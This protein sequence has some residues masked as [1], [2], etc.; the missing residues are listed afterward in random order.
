MVWPAVLS[1][2]VVV[3]FFGTL[4]AYLTV[5]LR[6]LD[7]I[8]GRPTSYLAKI[9]LGVRAIESETGMLGPQVSR[10]ND[11]ATALIGG[12]KAVGEDLEQVAQA[13]GGDR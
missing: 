5:I 9:R 8:G 13:V 6:T 7:R 4:I 12:L 11:G 10:L 3:L 1:A 2:L